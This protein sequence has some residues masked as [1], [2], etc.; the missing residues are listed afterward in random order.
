MLLSS[1]ERVSEPAAFFGGPNWRQSNMLQFTLWATR[2]P[3]L[4]IR[5]HPSFMQ[6]VKHGVTLFDMCIFTACRNEVVSL[7]DLEGLLRSWHR[8]KGT[9]AA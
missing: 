4:G 9:S 2:L 7:P 6:R 8:S 1:P 3:C 5:F